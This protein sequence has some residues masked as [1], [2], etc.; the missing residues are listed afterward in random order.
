MSDI[1]LQSFVQF[2]LA[3]C[4]AK[5][6]DNIVKLLSIV[7]CN[8]V[9]TFTYVKI[10]QRVKVCKPSLSE[11]SKRIY[12]KDKPTVINTCMDSNMDTVS[13]HGKEM[14]YRILSKVADD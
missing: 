6:S 7:N 2:I 14:T 1:R 10:S 8:H 13:D 4:L 11:R 5:Y 3:R 12:L 9:D